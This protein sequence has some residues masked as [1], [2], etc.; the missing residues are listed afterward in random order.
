M[1]QKEV[2]Q[3]RG[4]SLTLDIHLIPTHAKALLFACQ[5]GIVNLNKPLMAEICA[6]EIGIEARNGQDYPIGV[7]GLVG[8][9]VGYEG[10]NNLCGNILGS[11]CGNNLH[12][13]GRKINFVLSQC[14]KF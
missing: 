7:L 4:T 3:K 1:T 8:A 9:V 2:L 12:I 14:A 5:N 6:T 13:L 10:V 11:E